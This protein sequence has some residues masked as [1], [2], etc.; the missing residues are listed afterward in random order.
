MNRKLRVGILGA[1]GMVGQQFIMLLQNHPWFEITALCASEKSQGL[2][3]E[4]AVNNRWK[5]KSYIPNSV[6]QVI[7]NDACDVKSLIGKVDFVFSALSMSKEQIYVLEEEYAKAEIPVISNNSAHRTT[8]DVPMIIPEINGKHLEL[9]PIQKRRLGTNNGF[10]V[11]KP[12]C[13]IQSYVPPITVWKKYEPTKIVVST[14]QAVSGAGRSLEEWNQMRNNLI[15]YIEK[16]EEKSEAEPLRIWGEIRNNRM[17]SAIRPRISAQCVRVPVEYG[18]L[19]TVYIDFARKPSKE[20]MIE[21]LCR[22][23]GDPQKLNLPSAPKQFIKYMED[24]N[25]PQIL[26]D[27]YYENGMGITVGRIREDSIFD[28]K[29]VSLAHN[30]IRGA[31]GGA[32]L[33]AELLCAKGYLADYLF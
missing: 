4:E 12:N 2:T 25:R 3:Y 23:E 22:Y 17:E 5:M 26:D 11:V 10:I 1:T 21:A 31:A 20:E 33:C 24:N 27:V 7:V 32:I 14:Y 6:K 8:S 19:T 18:H 9:I 29:F 13:S 16:E 30:T 28:Y 15:P